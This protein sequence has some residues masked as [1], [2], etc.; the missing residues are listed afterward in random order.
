MYM[1]STP[2]LYLSNRKYQ[3][4]KS[5]VLIMHSLVSN[6]NN[7]IKDIH[8]TNLD[9]HSQVTQIYKNISMYP[10]HYLNMKPDKRE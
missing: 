9:T 4:L 1:R 8:K 2:V 10:Y 5:Y 6:Y 3:D 7:K